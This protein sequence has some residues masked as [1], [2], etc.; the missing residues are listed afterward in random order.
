MSIEFSCPHCFC[1]HKLKSASAGKKMTCTQCGK[2]IDVPGGQSPREP[3][4]LLVSPPIRERLLTLQGMLTLPQRPEIAASR[5]ADVEEALECVLPDEILA[6]LAVGIDSLLDEGFRLDRLVDYQKQ[7]AEARFPHDLICLGIDNGDAF[8]G[9]QRTLPRN[10]TP[11]ITTYLADD[12]STQFVSFSD[13][14]DELIERKRPDGGSDDDNE[15][16]TIVMSPN[17]DV[18]HFKPRLV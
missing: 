1:H 15:D 2:V 4:P 8:Y 17:E 7:A 5:V 9:I 13:W 3:R 18:L 14:L 16:G 12:S 11:G 6:A 10:R